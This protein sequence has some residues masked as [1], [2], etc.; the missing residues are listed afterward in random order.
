M[1]GDEL[2]AAILHSLNLGLV[3][4]ALSLPVLPG[5][6]ITEPA[7]YLQTEISPELRKSFSLLFL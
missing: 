3:L 2:P 4:F 7:A 5:L 1:R 6:T